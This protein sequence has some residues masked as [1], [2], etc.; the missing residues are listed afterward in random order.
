ML[1]F[2]GLALIKSLREFPQCNVTHDK[3][4]NLLL[5]RAAV[6]L[7]V[8]TQTPDGLKV[9]VVKHAEIQTVDGRNRYFLTAVRIDPVTNELEDVTIFD[10]NRRERQRTT[11]AERGSMAFNESKTDLYLT[12]FDGVVH[13]PQ[14][15]REGGFQRLY[16]QKQ[17]VPLRD[18]GNELVRQMGGAQRGDREMTFS[19]L[20]ERAAEQTGELEAVREEARVLS[21]ETLLMALGRPVAGDSAATRMAQLQRM[22]GEAAVGVGRTRSFLGRDDHTQGVVIRTR[23]FA[24][25]EESLRQSVN[26]YQVELHKKWALA[27]A[28]LVFTLV[29]PPIALR[30]PRGGVGMVIAASTMIFS[31]YWVGL[32]GGESLADKGLGDPLLTMWIPNVVF[33]AAG[34]LL[35]RRMGRAGETVRGGGSGTQWW[36][37]GGRVEAGLRPRAAAGT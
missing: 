6:H 18:V 36:A 16:F 37:R 34:V 3:D 35:V 19:Q 10:G 2:L 29:G 12:L 31:V 26:R 25:R 1:P 33:A 32:I 8:A 28:C 11:Y 5:Q 17:I 4:R 15:D 23:T 24:S 14:R 9:P 30:F 7:G 13:E 20:R 22:R 27:F 21:H